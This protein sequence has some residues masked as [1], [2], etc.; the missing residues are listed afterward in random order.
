MVK[1]PKKLVSNQNL[2]RLKNSSQKKHQKKMTNRINEGTKTKTGTIKKTPHIEDRISSTREGVEAEAVEGVI[3]E[4][5]V[6]VELDSDLT[7]FK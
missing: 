4:V 7:K 3:Q 6:V 5:A 1:G 2:L